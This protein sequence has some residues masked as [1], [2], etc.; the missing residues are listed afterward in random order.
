MGS[1]KNKW[2]FILV[3]LICLII[4]CFVSNKYNFQNSILANNIE[5]TN[6][7]I[8]TNV[9]NFD[10]NAI[11]N[12]ASYSYE[13]MIKQPILY[14][15]LDKNE[16]EKYLL[17]D[18]KKTKP[19]VYNNNSIY[20]VSYASYTYKEP[21]LNYLDSPKYYKKIEPIY[22]IENKEYCFSYNIDDKTDISIKQDTDKNFMGIKQL[23]NLTKYLYDEGAEVLRYKNTNDYLEIFFNNKVYLK[24]DY[25]LGAIDTICEWK[26]K[27]LSFVLQRKISINPSMPKFLFKIYGSDILNGVGQFDKYSVDKVAFINTK[28][29][30]RSSSVQVLIPA[31]AYDYED[32][33]DFGGIAINLDGMGC[34]IEDMNFDGYKDIRI[35]KN[36]SYKGTATYVCWTWDVQKQCF[37]VDRNLEE[38]PSITVDFDKKLIYGNINDSIGGT[39]STYQYID[40]V[41]T[42][43]YEIS[44]G[45]N[46]ENEN[47]DKNINNGV[48][49]ERK[50]IDGKMVEVKKEFFEWK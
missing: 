28:K 22:K 17:E 47:V 32:D 38:I 18:N 42:L 8:L 21:D 24:W 7:I 10:G 19:L 46:L 30:E 49:V 9:E 23:Y 5:N 12:V 43:I 39:K 1:Y 31:E 27:E 13:E 34:Y 41:I 25:N 44:L 4:L 20:Y 29:D 2:L 15:K 16:A 50:R 48:R 33:I 14:Y 40:G 37:V 11:Q 35:T 36:I 45:L 6:S 26:S 3:P